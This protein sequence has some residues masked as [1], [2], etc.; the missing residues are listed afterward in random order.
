MEPK[1]MVNQYYSH[2]VV[3]R[4]FGAQ[5][6]HIEALSDIRYSH[7]T[8]CVWTFEILF[9]YFMSNRARVG[10]SQGLSET[11]ETYMTRPY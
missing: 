4:L 5:I 10:K 1:I 8:V 6:G 9:V 3:L 2:Q 11:R 7:T